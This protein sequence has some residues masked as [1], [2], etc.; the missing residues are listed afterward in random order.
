MADKPGLAIILAGK[1]KPKPGESDGYAPSEECVRSV[2]HFFEAGQDGDFE[3]AAKALSTALDHIQ[4]DG[5]QEPE[6]PEEE[7]KDEE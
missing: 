3:G 1:G 7:S 4:S 6:P 5:G 2:K